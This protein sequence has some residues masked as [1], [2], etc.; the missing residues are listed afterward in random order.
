MTFCKDQ[1]VNVIANQKV[2]DDTLAEAFRK[3]GILVLA[4]IGTRGIRQLQ[5]MTK[6]SGLL[7]SVCQIESNQGRDFVSY[8]DKIEVVVGAN[9]KCYLKMNRFDSTLSTLVVHHWN[10]DY[11]SEIE[12]IALSLG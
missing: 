12:V 11:C 3:Q 10:E 9:N 4:R 8:I 6:C 2:F 7:T 1:G 5:S